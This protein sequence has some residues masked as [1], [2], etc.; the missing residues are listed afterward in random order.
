MSSA[1]SGVLSELDKEFKWNTLL[2][3]V[4]QHIRHCL[5]EPDLDDKDEPQTKKRKRTAD[6]DKPVSP[7]ASLLYCLHHLSDKGR[8]ALEYRM[9]KA[10]LAEIQSWTPDDQQRLYDVTTQMMR[11]HRLR[12]DTKLWDH[13]PTDKPPMALYA[14]F[15]RERRNELLEQQRNQRN[16]PTVQWHYPNL[17]K[18]WKELSVKSKKE[19]KERHEA[20]KKQYNIQLEEWNKIKRD[21]V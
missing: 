3:E 10:C 14:F 12:N 2:M 19:W 16:N 11:R 21:F 4:N 15:M 1:T 9:E 18:E 13:C 17:A 20:A 7:L 5:P 8:A 6:D